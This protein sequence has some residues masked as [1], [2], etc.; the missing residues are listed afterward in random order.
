MYFFVNSSILA[1]KM[2]VFLHVH[3]NKRPIGGQVVKMNL[4]VCLTTAGEFSFVWSFHSF[5]GLETPLL[6][7]V[8]LLIMLHG[9]SESCQ[10][11]LGDKY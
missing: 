9:F 6:C 2:Q 11:V 8:V 10:E 4:L 5:T 1:K 7:K 3:C